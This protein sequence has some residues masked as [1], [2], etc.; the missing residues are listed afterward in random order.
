MNRGVN[1]GEFIDPL[2]IQPMSDTHAA[3]KPNE[4]TS[5]EMAKVDSWFDAFESIFPDPE[6]RRAN[7]SI[8]K[9]GFSGKRVEYLAK[10]D[11][12]SA[13]FLEEYEEEKKIDAGGF[14]VNF[15]SLKDVKE[16]YVSQPIFTSMRKEDQRKFS[17]KKLKEDFEKNILLKT[18]ELKARGTWRAQ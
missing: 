15:V 8:L 6:L 14:I 18:Y 9:S 10:N 12:L 16:L 13:W 2:I 4:T 11:E 17:T 5:E 7:I 3:K 1:S